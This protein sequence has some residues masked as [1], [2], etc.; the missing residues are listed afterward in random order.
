[1]DTK[2]LLCAKRYARY[3]GYNDMIDMVVPSVPVEANMVA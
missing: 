1:M 2:Y 3:W